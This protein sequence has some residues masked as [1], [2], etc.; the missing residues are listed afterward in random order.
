MIGLD[1]TTAKT[2]NTFMSHYQNAEQ[3]H[4]INV[5]NKYS[6]EFRTV[7]IIKSFEDMIHKK[8]QD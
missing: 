8:M 6:K 2:M 4:N 5:A 7:Q 1:I 3:I